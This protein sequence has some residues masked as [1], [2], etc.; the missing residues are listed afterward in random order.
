MQPE[1]FDLPE[2]A[3]KDNPNINVFF[4]EA[5]AIRTKIKALQKEQDELDSQFRA[6]A[7]LLKDAIQETG[8]DQWQKE[9][10]FSAKIKKFFYINCRNEF[11]MDKIE[12]VKEKGRDDL[13]DVP[14]SKILTLLK[15][16]ANEKDISEKELEDFLKKELP[17]FITMYSET[18]LASLR[19]DGRSLYSTSK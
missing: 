2:D 5:V 14:T 15:Q 4:D 16:E 3:F 12:Y 1:K 7:K 19:F 9:K 13:I 6:V 11:R 8:G 10:G 17:D 18:K